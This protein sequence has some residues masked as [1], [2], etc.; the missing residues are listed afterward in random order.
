MARGDAGVTMLGAFSELGHPVLGALVLVEAA[1]VPVPGETALLTAGG[2]VAAGL[3]LGLVSARRRRPPSPATPW[4]TLRSA[5]APAP[6]CCAGAPWP[7]T[8]ARWRS[9][10]VAT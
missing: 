2:L 8:G 6:C 1:G 10:R 9:R 4:A 7:A 5:G 3:S